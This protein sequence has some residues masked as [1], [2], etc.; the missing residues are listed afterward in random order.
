MTYRFALNPNA[1]PSL[2]IDIDEALS[3]RPRLPL[4]ERMRETV[5]L[6]LC[7]FGASSCPGLREAEPC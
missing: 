3:F 6:E 5:G 4:V 1:A 7:G 2:A